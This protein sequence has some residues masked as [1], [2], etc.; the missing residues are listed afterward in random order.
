MQSV[1]KLRSRATAW[2]LLARES[3]KKPNLRD[4]L[5][6]S[7]T[8]V[9]IILG[10]SPMAAAGTVQFDPAASNNSLLQLYSSQGAFP[11]TGGTGALYENFALNGGKTSF[12]G[13]MVVNVTGFTGLGG[14]GIGLAP[15]WQLFAVVSL[16]GTANVSGTSFTAT[17][18]T[19]GIQLYGVNPNL[20]YTSHGGTTHSGFNTQGTVDFA[21]PGDS[22]RGTAV[23]DSDTSLS[24]SN[25]V[26]NGSNAGYNVGNRVNTEFSGNLVEPD[27][28]VGNASGNPACIDSSTKTSGGT[29]VDYLNSSPSFTGSQAN[30]ILLAYG[31]DTTSTAGNLSVTDTAG[32]YTTQ[33]TL[34]AALTAANYATGANGFFGSDTIPLDLTIVSGGGGSE[35]PI[36][37]SYDTGSSGQPN[38]YATDGGPVSFSLPQSV[39]EPGSL[40][41]F[42]TALLGLGAVRR[43]RRGFA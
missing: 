11:V 13:A 5:L 39:P 9:S 34:D 17:S 16:A 38:Y 33:F 10:A 25:L 21:T 14:T 37:A 30:C 36:T 19:F 32:V 41:L 27:G 43:R 35:S 6:A 23:P 26:N 12:N 40:S 22:A 4:H 24:V 29:G 20:T 1:Q 28:T 2:A 8:A 42:G 18:D 15:G 31:A 7:A 3:R